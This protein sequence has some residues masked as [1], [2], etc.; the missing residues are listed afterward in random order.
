MSYTSLNGYVR[1]GD[2][3]KVISHNFKHVNVAKKY[4][5]NWT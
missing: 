2:Q 4:L 5:E 1:V 3:I